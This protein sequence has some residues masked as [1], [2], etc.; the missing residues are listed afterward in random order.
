MDN[1]E[2]IRMAQAYCGNTAPD[3][4]RGKK[5]FITGASGFVGS[6]LTKAVMQLGATV[7]ALVRDTVKRS[8]LYDLEDVILVAGNV[9]DGR[10]LTR[11]ISDYEPDIIFHL[12]AQAVVT[13]ASRYPAEDFDTN[14]LGT[15]N[16]FQAINNAEVV[17]PSIVVASSDKVYGDAKLPYTEDTLP[18]AEWPYEV[19]KLC[20]EMIALTYSRRFLI[21]VAITRMANIYGPGDFTWNRLIPETIMNILS[22]KSPAIRSDGKYWRDYLYVDDAVN[23]YILLAQHLHT[24]PEAYSKNVFNFSSPDNLSAIEVVQTILRLMNSYRDPIIKN[25][26]SHEIRRQTVNYLRATKTLGYEPNWTFEMGL[27]KTIEW[28]RKYHESLVR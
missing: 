16:L 23:A 20:E 24:F 7:T 22:E 6:H 10:T 19:S 25:Q 28:Y 27:E 11:I 15:W 1:L 12:A 4:W 13:K 2:Y 3:F 8:L 26:A 21:P 18:V 5:V 14:C 17:R 9:I